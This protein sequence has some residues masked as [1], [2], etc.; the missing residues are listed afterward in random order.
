MKFQKTMAGKKLLILNKKQIQQR[1]D[2]MAYQILEDNLG[3]EEL[4]MAG[5]VDKGYVIAK[6]LKTV[7]ESISE[8]KVTL[9]KIEINKDISHLD[10][11]ADLDLDLVS[12]KV[13]I[14]VDDVL[15]S[16]RALAYGL[17]VFLDIP[18]K[19]LRTLVLIDRS[20]RNFP[21]SPDFTGLEL[22][23]IL[24]EHVDVVLDE[25]SEEDAVYLS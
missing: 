23:T 17:G 14:L 18:L 7:L 13:V 4:I 25:K 2:R 3:E 20:H 1:I 11:N 6:R 8:I 5:I 10:A 22:A 24:K 19:K 15:N 12:N 9:M 16:G 21:V